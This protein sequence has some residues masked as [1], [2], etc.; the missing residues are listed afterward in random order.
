MP[1]WMS[2]RGWEFGSTAGGKLH[3]SQPASVHIADE[4]LARYLYF[5]DAGKV[6]RERAK[7]GA[8]RI[9]VDRAKREEDQARMEKILRPAFGG[10][11]GDTSESLLEPPE[12]NLVSSDLPVRVHLED[13]LKASS[14]LPMQDLSEGNR[15]TLSVLPTKISPKSNPDTVSELPVNIPPFPIEAPLEDN[16]DALS[17]LPVEDTSETDSEENL[18]VFQSRIAKLKAIVAESA[19]QTEAGR[20]RA[21]PLQERWARIKNGTYVSL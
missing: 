3:G 18:E 16:P 10:E 4:S 13:V 17:E 14:G 2:E 19:R 11:V 12:E 6:M 9:L 8:R 15:D 7:V 5:Y 20:E 21:K 1:M